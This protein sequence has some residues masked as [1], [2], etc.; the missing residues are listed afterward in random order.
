V[1]E[2]QPIGDNLSKVVANV[3]VD[4]Q[5]YVGKQRADGLDVEVYRRIK[6]LKSILDMLP[7]SGF[8][9]SANEKNVRAVLSG[10]CLGA[11]TIKPGQSSCWSNG[12]MFAPHDGRCG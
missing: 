11:L 9:E 3:I 7:T 5:A 10:Y 8:P 2:V 4:N 12:T 1:L 6:E